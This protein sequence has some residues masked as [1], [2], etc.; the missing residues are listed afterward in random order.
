[1]HPGTC[2]HSGT[3]I[4]MLG[5]C[6]LMGKKCPC[7]V[8]I[9][10]TLCCCEGKGIVF[11]SLHIR[12]LEQRLYV[13]RTQYVLD[14]ISIIGPNHMGSNWQSEASK[15]GLFHPTTSI[16]FYHI[17]ASRKFCFLKP[18]ACFFRFMW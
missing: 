6:V 2:T 10:T 13:V 17:I 18:K 7:E 3:L 14:N 11:V 5:L 1:M 15:P 16:L 12:H 9:E 8:I 4:T